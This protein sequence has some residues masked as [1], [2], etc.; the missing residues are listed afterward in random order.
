[1]GAGGLA[2]FGASVARRERL[3]GPRPEKDLH[4]V[5]DGDDAGGERDSVADEPA[6]VSRAVPALMVVSDGV[7]R[8]ERRQRTGNEKFDAF[9]G[10]AMDEGSLCV[11]EGPGGV[12]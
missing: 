9:D 4:D 12:Q 11:E 6:G 2:E 10:V 8:R 3:V 7:D 1:M 5:G